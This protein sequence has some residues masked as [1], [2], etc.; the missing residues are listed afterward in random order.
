MTTTNFNLPA[1]PTQDKYNYKHYFILKDNTREDK[2]YLYLLMYEPESM[3]VDSSGRFSFLHKYGKFINYNEMIFY[4]GQEKWTHSQTC[5]YP[6]HQYSRIADLLIYHNFTMEFGED[7]FNSNPM[8]DDGVVAAATAEFPAVP[9]TSVYQYNHY[10][11]TQDKT[12][13]KNYHLYLL[14]YEPSEMSVNAG[15]Y[16]AVYQ[17]YGNVLAG[18]HWT[19]TLGNDRWYKDRDYTTPFHYYSNFEG[20]LIYNNFVMNIEGI[21][22]D[23][24]PQPNDQMLP[25]PDMELPK[26]PDSTGYYYKHYYITQDKVYLETYHLYMLQYTPDKVEINERD[27]LAASQKYGK[28]IAVTHYSCNIG[29]ESWSYKYNYTSPFH[30]YDYIKDALIYNNFAM[31][32]KGLRYEENPMPDDQLSPVP[33]LE[34]PL[35]PDNSSFYHKHYYITQDKTY[36]ETYHLYMF[37]YEPDK[38]E[39]DERGYVVAYQKYGRFIETVHY[40]CNTGGER[41]SKN[42]TYTTP[43]HHYDTFKDSLIYNNF[44]MELKGIKYVKNPLPN[45]KLTPAPELSLPPLYDFHNFRSKFYYIVQDKTYLERYHLYQLIYEPASMEVDENGYVVQYQKYGKLIN[46]THYYCN[47]GA[48][49]WY[50]ERDYTYPFHHYSN[51]EG[52]LIYNN[53]DMELK[54]IKYVKNPLPNDGV[55]PPL[56]LSLPPLYDYSKF[57]YKTY[58]ITQ[59]KTTLELYH[60]YQLAYEPDYMEVDENGYVT[61]YHKY[62]HLISGAHYQFSLGG[63]RWYKDRDY[64]YPFH[65]VSAFEDALIY[66]N[67]RMD[68]GDKTYHRN[69]LPAD[70]IEAAWEPEFPAIPG[71][72]K[73]QYK[74]YY[75]NQ[76]EKILQMYHLYVFAYK[77]ESLEVHTDGTI[78]LHNKFGRKI[79]CTHYTYSIGQSQST[80]NFDRNSDQPYQLY[81]TLARTLIY[82]NFDISVGC[83]YFKANRLPGEEI[84]PLMEPVFQPVPQVFG[85]NGD[86]F[87]YYLV[88]QDL[89]SLDTYWMYLLENIPAEY[90][91]TANDI[92]LKDKDGSWVTT[93]IYK[94]VVGSDGWNYHGRTYWLYRPNIS[95]DFTFCNFDLYV[96]SGAETILDVPTNPFPGDGIGI[97]SPMNGLTKVD[98]NMYY[99]KN[100]IRQTGWVSLGLQRSNYKIYCQGK[101]VGRVIS[102]DK[103]HIDG[104]YYDFDSVGK[105]SSLKE[106]QYVTFCVN[107]STPLFKNNKIQSNI[108]LKVGSVVEAVLIN[109]TNVIRYDMGDSTPFIQIFYNHGLYTTGWVQKSALQGKALA[110]EGIDLSES[111]REQI[112][113]IITSDNRWSQKADLITS[114]YERHLYSQAPEYFNEYGR[115]RTEYGKTDHRTLSAEMSL[116]SFLQSSGI[117][118]RRV[119]QVMGDDVMRVMPF[120]YGSII[121]QLYDFAQ[122]VNTGKPAD[123]KSRILG[124]ALGST[125]E[126]PLL[127]FSVWARE[128]ESGLRPDY[129]GNYYYGY[130]GAA[131]FKGFDFDDIDFLEDLKIEIPIFGEV[132]VDKSY[133]MAVDELRK[134]NTD[135]TDAEIMLLMSAGMAQFLSDK[136]V[137]KYIENALNG[138][139]GDNPEDS[140]YASEGINDYYSVKGVKKAEIIEEERN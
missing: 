122:L 43:F 30:H 36:L 123:L 40:K 28:N 118:I 58:Y 33:E 34:L 73:N 54:E 22:Y 112:E 25:V 64:T 17:K 83:D 77:P 26:V 109:N 101:K 129:L 16:L 115:M 72:D 52:A 98:G 93:Y 79:P 42:Y 8:P 138:Y 78:A 90:S 70:G 134:N 103:Q 135:K 119:T 113:A 137:E 75:I 32:L 125:P 48:V 44:E 99:F 12:D 87:R 31:E 61:G 6:Y 74:H 97:G 24:N 94:Y 13:L 66:N 124:N 49:S 130:N 86:L 105:A 35:L 37:L 18:S 139:W 104:K 92:Y 4:T 91:V 57:D 14:K 68:I 67:F 10:Y 46:G 88:Y 21:V 41:W 117:D 59:D 85:N 110:A 127:N 102:D 2:F 15:G 20:A 121:L 53:F 9:Y 55:T 81:S 140:A 3:E 82:H 51:Y 56:K 116:N 100:G 62:G 108:K 133:R 11:I 128:W 76:D 132:D 89:N 111:Y 71:N 5:T 60:L 45:E 84:V 131:Y 136:N 7:K 95:R 1:I 19:F 65:H 39:V 50:K 106:L 80:W 107:E 27:Y 114:V 69:P 126:A 63:E 29:Q 120:T 38:V 23:K 47:S 96:T